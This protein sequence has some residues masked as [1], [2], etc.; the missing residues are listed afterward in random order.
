MGI[1]MRVQIS[2]QSCADLINALNPGDV[3]MDNL[4]GYGTGFRLSPDRHQAITYDIYK[5]FGSDAFRIYMC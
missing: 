2:Y 3:S 5:G 4:V 1:H